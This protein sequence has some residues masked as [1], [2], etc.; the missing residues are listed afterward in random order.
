MRFVDH[1][2]FTK[3]AGWTV[4]VVVLLIVARFAW[5][6]QENNLAFDSDLIAL[7]PKV[8]E[9]PLVEEMER[10]ISTEV[11]S[12]VIIIIQGEN[13][14]QVDSATDN[15][16]VLTQESIDQGEIA[17]VLIDGPDVEGVTERINAML[18]YKDRLIGDISRQRMQDSVDAQLRW[19]S[20]RVI[21]FPPSNLTDPV[22]DPLGTL[23][24][25]VEERLPRL[26]KIQS[27][28]L[29]F[30]VDNKIPA[31]M[32]LLKLVADEI[33][34]DK[35]E[36]SINRLFAI[37]EEI[38]Q[39]YNVKMFATGIPLHATQIKRATVTEIS[40][41]GPMALFLTLALFFFITRSPRALLVTVVST[42]L[43]FFGGLVFAQGT[44]G[45]PHL[46]GLT[47]TTTAIGICVD[48][49]FHF[50]IHV[51]SGKSG[52]EA[53]NAIRSAV[54]MG[55]ITTSIGL[56][57]II[58]ISVPVLA[59]TAVFIVGALLI[60]WL[61]VIFVFPLLVGGATKHPIKKFAWYGMMPNKIATG[62]ILAVSVFSLLGF[63]LKIPH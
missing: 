54:N 42:V 55:F 8:S 52:L 41:M 16:S 47:M 28:G 1:P 39:K 10:R 25:F 4:G 5:L 46:I 21:Q 33:G 51:R 38:E 50:W 34:G 27:D 3:A 59:K 24:E 58:L 56:A 9:A 18:G 14:E 43:A 62:F 2:N 35:S 63:A 61:L 23:E 13:P 36:T 22:L 31:N 30:R 45:L 12:S 49:S 7:L 57:A 29:Y 19:R 32:L 20:D 40:W 15:I 17:A 44:I 26:G 48:F 37:Q 6:V 60:S 11:K 53:I